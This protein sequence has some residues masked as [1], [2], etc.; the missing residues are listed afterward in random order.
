LVFFLPKFFQSKSLD[1]ELMLVSDGL[2]KTWTVVR[3]EDELVD[4]YFDNDL[5]IKII[6]I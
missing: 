5:N 1:Y 6:A 2:K 3:P 4:E